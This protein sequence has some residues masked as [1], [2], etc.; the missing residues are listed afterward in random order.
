MRVYMTITSH[1]TSLSLSLWTC[2]QNKLSFNWTE[3][4]NNKQTERKVAAVGRGWF[5]SLSSDTAQ[6]WNPVTV[7]SEHGKLPLINYGCRMTRGYFQS[8]CPW[9]YSLRR[10][11]TQVCCDMACLTFR[12]KEKRDPF[13]NLQSACPSPTVRVDCLRHNTLNI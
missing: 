13:T 8:P 7:I 3:P 9:S 11:R 1:I 6:R 12:E 4:E 5:H 10:E 2:D